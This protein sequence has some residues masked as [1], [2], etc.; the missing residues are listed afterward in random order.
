[1]NDPLPPDPIDDLVAAH[2][3][4][5]EGHVDAAPLLERIEADLRLNTALSASSTDGRR[6]RRIAM[7]GL[8]AAVVL[9]AFLGGRYFDARAVHAA[10]LLKSV[11]FVH[12]QLVD[13][14]YLVQHAAERSADSRSPDAASE[15]ILW[16]RGDSF[17]SDAA[18]GAKR[19]KLGRED[20]GTLWL[21]PNPKKGIRFSPE[22]TAFPPEV[23]TLCQI[24]SM[25]VPVLV[26]EV[27]ADFDLRTDRPVNGPDG[28]RSVVWANLKKGRSHAFLSAA[29]LEVDVETNLLVRLVLWLHKAHGPNG[30]VTYTLV[31]RPAPGDASYRLETYLDSDAVI[32][33]HTFPQK[34]PAK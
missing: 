5:L 14:C 31:D 21:A 26:D 11:R 20:S 30:T 13:R 29:M 27:L 23:E 28:Q 33:D 19:L 3:R 7:A 24:S 6:I 2:L 9:I 34:K 22:K 12:R 18:L 17:W 32:E 1:M 16:T 10:T 8:M 15:S 25:T 4:Q